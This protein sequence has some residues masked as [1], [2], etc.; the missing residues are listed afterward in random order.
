LLFSIR[1]RGSSCLGNESIPILIARD[2]DQ[3]LSGRAMAWQNDRH[4]YQSGRQRYRLQLTRL[5]TTISSGIPEVHRLCDDR[6]I[7]CR[8]ISV[9]PISDGH[10]C[11]CYQGA[12]C[13]GHSKSHPLP[14]RAVLS[15]EFKEA[16]HAC[17][18]VCCVIDPRIGEG[19]VLG[20]A[21]KVLK[22]P[23]IWA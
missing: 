22:E 20:L 21:G 13:D 23:L 16:S 15:P 2:C 14:A 19:N 4:P 3:V 9:H 5:I 11:H 1:N 12:G 18:T 8:S 7:G 6:S 17:G 10:H